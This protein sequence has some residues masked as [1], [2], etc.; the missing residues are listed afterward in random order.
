MSVRPATVIAARRPLCL[1][2][3]LAAFV[4]CAAP[5]QKEMDQADGAIAAA[6]AAGAAEYAQEEFAAAEAALKRSHEAVEQRDYRQALN[7]ALDA[8]ERAQAAAR[9]AA[10]KQAQARGQAERVIA[11]TEVALTNAR[12]QL[13]PTTPSSS[14]RP[15]PNAAALKSLDDVEK[16]LQEARSAVQ[17]QRYHVA[18]ETASP[19]MA[20]IRAATDAAEATRAPQTPARG[21]RRPR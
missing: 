14:R 10:D 3:A 20:Q 7:Q 19:L 21:A 5:P 6:R 4:A 9:E 17:A 12:R 15:N 8:R 1:A 13:T 2:V 11:E 18:L 16:A